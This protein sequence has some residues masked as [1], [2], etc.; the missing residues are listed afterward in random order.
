MVLKKSADGV[1]EGSC[2]LLVAWCARWMGGGGSIPSDS[3]LDLPSQ[4]GSI[5]IS[6]PQW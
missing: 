3:V 2:W 1:G 5:P 4:A 6:D